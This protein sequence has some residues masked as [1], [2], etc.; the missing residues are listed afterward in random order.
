[1]AFTE[2]AIRRGSP[3]HRTTARLTPSSFALS[4]ALRLTTAIAKMP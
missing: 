4:S 2:G 1:M 3:G